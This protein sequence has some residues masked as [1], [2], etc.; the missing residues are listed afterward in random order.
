MSTRFTV[1][2]Y[3]FERMNSFKREN[4]PKIIHAFHFSKHRQ[5]IDLDHDINKKRRI[6]RRQIVENS[7]SE[8]KENPVFDLIICHLE[9]KKKKK[10]NWEVGEIVYFPEFY[11]EVGMAQLD[12]TFNFL[13]LLQQYAPCSEN[14][15]PLPLSWQVIPCFFPLPQLHDRYTAKHWSIIAPLS[16][17]MLQRGF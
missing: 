6:F 4:I 15:L 5:S 16:N 12:S 9:K 14:L 17:K 10:A 7:S 8:K 3:S 13:R 2:H 1:G 11:S